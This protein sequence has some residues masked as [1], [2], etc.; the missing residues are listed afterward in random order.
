MGPVQ[1]Q[2]QSYRS[3][4]RGESCNRVS[5]TCQVGDGIAE[6]RTLHDAR[7]ALKAVGFEIVHEEDLAARK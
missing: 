7:K 3:R 6:M 5:L 1:P 4:H 2:A